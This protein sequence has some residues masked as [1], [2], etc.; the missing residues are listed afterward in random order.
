[1][2]I[3]GALFRNEKKSDRAPD[4]K[5]VAQELNDAGD[6][7][8]ELDIAAWIKTAKS[9]K[10]YLS[11]SIKDKYVSSQKEQQNKNEPDDLPL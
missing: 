3:R 2:N 8:K 7:K 6:T 10:Q 1:M 4:F 9:G 11:V 5:G